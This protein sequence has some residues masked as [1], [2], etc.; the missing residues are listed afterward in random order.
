M[1]TI[2]ATILAGK[3]AFQWPPLPSPYPDPLR[4]GNPVTCAR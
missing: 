3:G 2:K 1:K 4:P